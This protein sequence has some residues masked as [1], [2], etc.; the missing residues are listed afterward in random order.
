MVYVF[1]YGVFIFGHI[2]N[3]LCVFGGSTGVLETRPDMSPPVGGGR[4]TGEVSLSY[5]VEQFPGDFDKR[6]AS[7]AMSLLE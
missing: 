5:K 3:C 4:P 2:C 1:M 6:E 7:H